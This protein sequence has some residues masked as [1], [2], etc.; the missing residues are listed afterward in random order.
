MNRISYLKR[1]ERDLKLFKVVALL[2]SRQVGKT[3]IAREYC[4]SLKD[5][6]WRT[7]YFDLEDPTALLR[8]QDPKL[9]LSA[10]EGLVVIDEIQRR[11]DLFSVLRYLLDR[12]EN[13]LQLLILGSASRELIQQSSESLAG[14]IS[15]LEVHPFGLDETAA[16][17]ISGPDNDLWLRG[18]YPLAYLADTDEQAFRW[19]GSFIK[20][21][22]EQDIP[23]LGINIPAETL[24]RFWM[25]LVHTHG[26]ILNSAE[27]ARSFGIAD[28]TARRYLDLLSGTF[29]IRQL[30]PYFA[31]VKK[32]QIKSPKIY[33]RDSG[34]LHQMMGISDMAGLT[35]HLKCGASWEGFALEQIVRAINASNDQCYFWGIHGQGE[36]DL[37]VQRKGALKAFEFKFSSAPA[38]TKSMQLALKTLPIEGIQIVAPV[39]TSFAIHE[40]VTVSPL[41]ELIQSLT[42][43]NLEP[44]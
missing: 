5:F 31:N 16:L 13:K 6:P 11:P 25:M 8:L 17:S 37:L 28:T 3:T 44:A 35:T 32:R 23:N 40:Q 7:H 21:Y 42:D 34:L 2:G 15:Y 10:L 43:R 14:R 29:M 41:G 9:A 33:F 22:L 38:L 24:R 12:P 26:N 36:L 1:I 39:E 27:L 30:Q 4:K 18:G 19:L 20:T